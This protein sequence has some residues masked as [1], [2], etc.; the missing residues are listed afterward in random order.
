[1]SQPI[2]KKKPEKYRADLVARLCR[3]YINKLKTVPAKLGNVERR[4]YHEQFK[5]ELEVEC[6]KNKI[7]FD[8]IKTVLGIN[9]KKN[10]DETN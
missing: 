7:S 2:T 8:F 3:F 10:I 6:I 4:V 5:V 9:E 1:M